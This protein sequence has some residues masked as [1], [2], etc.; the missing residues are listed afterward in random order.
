MRNIKYKTKFQARALRKNV[1]HS[2]GKI[3]FRRLTRRFHCALSGMFIVSE[4]HASLFS[5]CLTVLFPKSLALMAVSWLSSPACHLAD[6]TS[7]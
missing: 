3:W 5:C 6:A 2:E 1:D 4:S 7:I